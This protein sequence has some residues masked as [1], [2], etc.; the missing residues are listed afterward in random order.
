MFAVGGKLGEWREKFA[1]L[2]PVRKAVLRIGE[3]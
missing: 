3:R 2:C 1:I